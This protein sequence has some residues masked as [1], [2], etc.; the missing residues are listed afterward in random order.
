MI[1][2]VLVVV[3]AKLI[4]G[5]AFAAKFFIFAFE[6]GKFKFGAFT[7]SSQKKSFYLGDY[8]VL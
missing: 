4:S 3:V 2:I 6:I 5:D 8:C 7:C 1:R